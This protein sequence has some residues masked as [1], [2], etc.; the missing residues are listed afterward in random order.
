[1]RN[2]RKY[3]FDHRKHKYELAEKQIKNV[4]EFYRPKVNNQSSY[5]L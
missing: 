3:H 5:G 4:T 1:M 2:Y